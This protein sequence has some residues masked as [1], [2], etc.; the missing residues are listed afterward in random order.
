MQLKYK[1]S[2]P[3]FMSSIGFLLIA[4]LLMSV[5]ALA[6]EMGFLIGI[7]VTEYLIILLPIFSIA[8]IAK[9]NIISAL[10]FKTISFG[11][12]WRIVLMSAFFLPIVGFVNFFSIFLLSFGGYVEPN[13]IPNPDSVSLLLWHLLLV[14]ISAGLSEEIFF[15]GMMLS[16]FKERMS[17]RT[18][19]FWVAILFGIFHFNMQNFFGPVVLGILFGHLV[20]VTDSIWSSV[21]AHSVNNGLAVML[22]YYFEATSKA[23]SSMEMATEIAEQL[24]PMD[25]LPTLIFLG[26]LATV[27]LVIV[28]KIFKSI[29][30]IARTDTQDKINVDVDESSEKK[31]I[32]W[33]ELLPILCV[34]LIY[35]MYMRGVF[36]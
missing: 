32:R 7:F 15:R 36:I 25:Y 4:L 34:C 28:R 17:S 20:L 26:L 2:Y 21:I 9:V 24:L 8:K 19:I 6:Q 18:A 5:G 31:G 14:A 10:R 29:V 12:V 33:Y 16:A 11:I 13:S 22:G 27:S 3:F 30:K 23:D 35:I 1:N